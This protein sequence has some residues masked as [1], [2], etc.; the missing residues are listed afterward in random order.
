MGSLSVC[1]SSSICRSKLSIFW[2]CKH[3]GDNSV[4]SISCSEFAFNQAEN[5]VL[6]VINDEEHDELIVV[7]VGRHLRPLEQVF[8]RKVRIFALAEV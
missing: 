7:D 6:G 4:Y 2:L 3:G 5:M 8:L 1:Q